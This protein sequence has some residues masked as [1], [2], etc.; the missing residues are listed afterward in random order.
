MGGNSPHDELTESE[1]LTLAIRYQVAYTLDPIETFSQL[2]T[3]Y[4]KENTNRIIRWMETLPECKIALYVDDETTID[5][6]G[7]LDP[8]H[9]LNRL[10]DAS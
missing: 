5:E 3:L 2:V 7:G 4:G 8:S 10:P 9:P 1:L 6:S